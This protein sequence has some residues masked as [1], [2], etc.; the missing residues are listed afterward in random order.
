[1]SAI[2]VDVSSGRAA[3]AAAV[4]RA[5]VARN[6]GAPQRVWITSLEAELRPLLVQDA[7]L[8]AGVSRIG[9][10]KEAPGRAHFQGCPNLEDLR[11]ILPV[12]VC[13]TAALEDGR[14]DFE[15]HVTRFINKAAPRTAQQAARDF[16]AS[17]LWRAGEERQWR[18]HAFASSLLKNLAKATRF[19]PALGPLFQASG[20]L[21]AQVTAVSELLLCTAGLREAVDLWIFQGLGCQK[22]WAPE[23]YVVCGFH[24]RRSALGTDWGVL[25]PVL[26]RRILDFIFPESQPAQRDV[27]RSMPLH[28][29]ETEVALIFGHLLWNCPKALWGVWA[30]TALMVAETLLSRRMT[31]FGPGEAGTGSPQPDSSRVHQ[32]ALLLAVLCGRLLKEPLQGMISRATKLTDKLKGAVAGAGQIEGSVRHCVKCAAESAATLSDG[33]AMRIQ[34]AW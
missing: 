11:S 13:R 6:Q 15:R 21:R 9:W 20:T 12:F 25:P 29:T 22:L 2:V 24:R 17:G 27:T 16:A 10:H 28:A 31:S 7:E 19:R 32:T 30:P 14:R 34:T 4:L 26:L 5:M 23:R 33:E 18:L 1:M 3:A 8:E